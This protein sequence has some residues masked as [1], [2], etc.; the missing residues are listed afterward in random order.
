MDSGSPQSLG[1][2]YWEVCYLGQRGGVKFGC[3]SLLEEIFLFP[4]GT[5]AL[6]CFASLTFV[7]HASTLCAS[8]GL[9]RLAWFGRIHGFEDEMA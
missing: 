8:A 2:R 7:L 9:S 1:V 6:L 5:A 4:A 3:L